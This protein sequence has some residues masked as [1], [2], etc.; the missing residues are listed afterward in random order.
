MFN[1]NHRKANPNKIVSAFGKVIN[2]ILLFSLILTSCKPI[3]TIKPQE[4]AEPTPLAAQVT[5]VP[6]Q[7]AEYEP[8]VFVQ[9]EPRTADNSDSPADPTLVTENTNELTIDQLLEKQE[10]IKSDSKAEFLAVQSN[11]IAKIADHKEQFKSFTI[12]PNPV[13]KITPRQQSSDEFQAVILSKEQ[14][15][16]SPFATGKPIGSPSIH[17][18]GNTYTVTNLTDLDDGVCDSD[19]SLREA[20]YAANNSA[21]ADTI[22][23]SLNGTINL[24]STLPYIEDPAGLTI[25]GT[26]QTVTVKGNGTNQVF[27]I[28]SDVSLTSNEVSFSS[29]YFYNA[30]EFTI[31]DT[32]IIN[33]GMYIGGDGEV[34]ITNCTFIDAGIYYEGSV[35]ISNC[36]YDNGRIFS[37]GSVTIIDSQF[38]NNSSVYSTGALLITNSPIFRK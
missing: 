33:E 24:E 8:P 31:T 17:N 22:I 21:G 1:L 19:C 23:F 13:R 9:P 26:G 30:G 25:D 12:A 28:S 15:V 7:A 5:D 6:Q 20:I 27:Y 32:T 38:R 2:V 4:T 11:M 37:L 16:N 34:I 36:S 3:N 14:M 35:L 18:E 10:Q 29:G